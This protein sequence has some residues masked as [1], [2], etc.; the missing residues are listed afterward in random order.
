MEHT[1]PDVLV[2]DKAVYF[3]GQELPW[4]IAEDGIRFK[5]GG[6]FDINTLTVD[7][8]VNS[9]TFEGDRPPSRSAA[10]QARWGFIECRIHLADYDAH[11]EINR[12]MKEYM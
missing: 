7:F 8:F 3:D 2:T 6:R 9:V 5:P 4:H 1:S 11:M 12:V 10:Y